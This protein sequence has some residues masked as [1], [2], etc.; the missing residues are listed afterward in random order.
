ML[1]LAWDTAAAQTSLALARTEPGEAPEILG[2]R[3]G[4]GQSSHSAFLG[5]AIMETLAENGLSP[6]SLDLIACGR[7]PGSF[8]GVRVG[9]ALAKGLAMG[10]GIPVVGLGSLPVLAQGAKEGRDEPFLA[11]ALVDARHQEVFAAL[12]RV[13]SGGPPE[14]LSPVAAIRPEALPSFLA[15]LIGEGAEAVITGPGLSLVPQAILEAAKMASS[16]LELGPSGPPRAAVLAIMAAEAYLRPGALADN[17]PE[18]IYGRS[19]EI[20]KSW[21]RPARL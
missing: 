16:P 11:A 7:G 19:P 5:P 21:A 9:L 14:A 6:K 13:G 15:E 4:D 12:F 10:A 17:P 8:T 18:P 3:L 1:T 2:E 20:F